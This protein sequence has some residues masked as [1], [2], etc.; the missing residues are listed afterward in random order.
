MTPRNQ[1][2]SGEIREENDMEQNKRIS[3]ED[4]RSGGRAE[5][6]EELPK[7]NDEK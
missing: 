5:Q 2:Q 6:T 3:R 1:S 7:G 4:I